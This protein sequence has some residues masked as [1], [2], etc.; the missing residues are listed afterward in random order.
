MTRRSRTGDVALAVAVAAVQVAG[1]YLAGRHQAD[2]KSFD[3]LAALLVAAGPT[4]L[5]VRWRFP[6]AVLGWA[7]ATTLA[8]V[9]LDYPRGPIFFALIV[10]FFTAVL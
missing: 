1:T 2:R 4:A 9:A 5:V 10:A 6:V 7:F 3:A 8:Y